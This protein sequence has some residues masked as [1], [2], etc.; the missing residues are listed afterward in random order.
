[1]LEPQKHLWGH[2]K[3]CNTT[4]SFKTDDRRLLAGCCCSA[5]QWGQN[6]F[7]IALVLSDV[8]IS[9]WFMK[10]SE[11]IPWPWRYV[12]IKSPAFKMVVS[13]I[14]T[15]SYSLLAG[16]CHWNL[17]RQDQC[18]CSLGLNTSTPHQHF[19]AK[20]FLKIYRYRR[21]LHYR[22]FFNTQ[23]ELLN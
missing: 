18:G 22:H 21:K 6:F 7:D 9:F 16:R 17:F 23:N 20:Q 11:T 15:A 10:I 2:E 1:M 8:F 14:C 4:P 13:P 5:T 19:M 3:C 12:R